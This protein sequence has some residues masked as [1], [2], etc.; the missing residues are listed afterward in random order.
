MP[1]ILCAT[2]V[3]FEMT[4]LLKHPKEKQIFLAENSCIQKCTPLQDS[5]KCSL[6]ATSTSCTEAANGAK[7]HAPYTLSVEKGEVV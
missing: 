4:N 3:P 2:W 6:Y 1:V 7:D 5:S